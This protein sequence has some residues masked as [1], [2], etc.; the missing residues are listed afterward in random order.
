M[1]TI[2]CS[3]QISAKIFLKEALQIQ[4]S[5][6]DLSEKPDSVLWFGILSFHFLIKGPL[7]VSVT[8]Q[9][10]SNMAEWQVHNL[11]TTG[12]NSNLN[13]TCSTSEQSPVI[14]L[15]IG[16]TVVLKIV[17]RIQR[18]NRGV[19]NERKF[20]F[21]CCPVFTIRISSE[22]ILQV[23]TTPWKAN[24]AFTIIWLLLDLYSNKSPFLE[25]PPF[26]STTLQ[27]PRSFSWVTAID[28]LQSA[29]QVFPQHFKKFQLNYVYC[30]YIL[31]LIVCT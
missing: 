15:S 4:S 29:L 8:Y 10:C 20:T 2:L 19:L 6:R 16:V 3:S 13:S 1:L 31:P 12:L 22:P 27:D 24:N 7:Q 23:S 14:L 5:S 30:A 9:A 17:L 26:M 18:G 11:S 28:T 25:S 21:F